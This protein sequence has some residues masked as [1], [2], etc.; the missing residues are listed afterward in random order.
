MCRSI[1]FILA[2]KIICFFCTDAFA[3]Q[4]ANSE[5]MNLSDDNVVLVQVFV[6]KID[7]QEVI[8]IYQY[9]GGYLVP[10]GLLSDILEFS[11]KVDSKQKIANGWFIKENRI[12]ALD[13]TANEVIVDG[14]EKKL[15]QRL[16]NGNEY[17][18][19][20]DSSL[21]SEW[22]PVDLDL[23]FFDL[24]LNVKPREY[25]PFQSRMEREKLRAKSFTSTNT[26]ENYEV[27]KVPYKAFAYPFVDFDL[28]YD[29]GN[30]N[31]PVNRTSYAVTAQGDFLY[32]TTQLSVAGESEDS[33]T[34]LRLNMGRSDDS[35]G[36]L[37]EVDAKSYLFGDIT[38]IPVSLVSDRSSGLGVTFSNT[39][40]DIADEFDSTNFIGDSQPGWEVELYRNG[41]LLD[42]Q[43]IEDNG[44]YEFNDVPIFF[45]NNIFRIVSYGPQGQVREETKTYLIDNSILD[46]GK[47]NY[48]LSLDKKSAS[49]F[50]VDEERLTI[51]HKDGERY[52]A[53]FDYG[54]LQSVTASL[55]FVRTPLE[56]GKFHEYQSVGVRKSFTDILSAG[57]LTDF[58]FVYDSTTGNWAT[59]MLANTSIKDI[60]V[61]V[62]QA[63]YDNFISEIEKADSPVR[64]S[65]TKVEIDGAFNKFIP[66]GVAYR[67][68]VELESFLNNREVK[69]LSN[70][71]NTSLK[72]VGFGNNIELSSITDSGNMETIADGSFSIRARYKSTSFRVSTDYGVTPQS[73]IKNLNFSVQK[74]ITPD[75]NAIF[76]IRK[77]LIGEDLTSFSS[78]FNTRFKYFTLSTLASIDNKSNITAGT[79][80]SFSIG[81]EPRHNQW[82]FKDRDISSDGAVSLAAFLDNNYNGK[83]DDG[84][85]TLPDIGFVT[86]AGQADSEGDSAVVVAGIQPYKASPVKIDMGTLEDPFWVPKVEGYKVVTRPGVFA[87]LNFPVHVTTEIDG[88]VYLHQGESQKGLPRA[89]VQLVNEKGELVSETKSEFDGFYIFSNVVPG[90]YIIKISD[91]TLK[92]LGDVKSAQRTLNIAKNSDIVSAIDIII[93]SFEPLPAVATEKE[94][95]A[96]IP[97]EIQEKTPEFVP[98][99]TPQVLPK[100]II[101]ELDE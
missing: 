19:Y 11:I 16:I 56:D 7:T 85:E 99:S 12:F 52:V 15:D 2:F 34:A 59:E 9:D 86:N 94:I 80:V 20:V 58:N 18:I 71:L 65:T 78:S 17:D 42:F 60:A 87:Q 90:K 22:L 98:Q 89:L 8:E 100:V 5:K 6:E 31:E 57:M 37:G 75:S 51:Q 35:G 36:L 88:T 3:V 76:D 25:L 82:F 23:N 46:K 70:S 45:G 73:E 28:G 68:G 10:L 63:F 81:N 91:A 1:L 64:T 77:D 61:K 93:Q 79:R 41:V 92:D 74:Q 21:F 43:I 67:F 30:N 54:I 26:E 40:L 24:I 72:G 39:D 14:I 69:T 83:F 13:V 47:F 84:D 53:N 50:G 96:E 29:Y 101:K 66:E 4:D 27:V 32:H 48:Q 44:K 55:G 38:S 95:E 97:E 62:R 49:L 33:L